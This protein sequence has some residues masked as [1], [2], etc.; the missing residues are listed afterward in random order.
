MWIRIQFPKIMRIHAEPDPQ[1]CSVRYGKDLFRW[2]ILSG[3]CLGVSILQ[4]PHQ[5]ALKSTNTGLLLPITL[6]WKNK[7]KTA[8]ERS[9]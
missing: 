4:G 7:E 6:F 9:V 8:V 2:K 3:G 1:P 5:V